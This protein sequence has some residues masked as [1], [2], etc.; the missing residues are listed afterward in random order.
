[1][2]DF[3]KSIVFTK[4]IK[5]QIF[6]ILGQKLNTIGVK[7]LMLVNLKIDCINF[8]FILT[9]LYLWMHIY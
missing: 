4:L 6:K 8:E 2:E 9:Q 3:V 1:M 7:I 5:I